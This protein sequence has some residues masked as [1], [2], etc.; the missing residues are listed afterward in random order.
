MVFLT[1]LINFAI[2]TSA[3]GSLSGPRNKIAMTEIRS[4]SV[5]PIPNIHDL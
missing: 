2:S 1:P 3:L 4:N 5:N